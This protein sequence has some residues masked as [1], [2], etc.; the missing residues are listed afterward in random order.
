MVSGPQLAG[1]EHCHASDVSDGFWIIGNGAEGGGIPPVTPDPGSS[2]GIP[3][4]PVA[5]I[6]L[7]GAAGSAGSSVLE[8]PTPAPAPAPAPAQPE[9][10]SKG[11]FKGTD[12][13][14]AKIDP[15]P[16]QPARK[17]ADTGAD[18]RGVIAASLIMMLA[19]ASALAFR[20]RKHIN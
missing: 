12:K 17:L 13:G 15:A 8:T 7:L 19:G 16:A 1:S 14:I 6:P 18:V 20:A 5:L 2:A 3:W 10:P 9:A 4:W 11:I